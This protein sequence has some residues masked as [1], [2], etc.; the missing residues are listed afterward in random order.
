MSSSWDTDREGTLLGTEEFSKNLGN[1]KQG[2][3][4]SR[5]NE[6]LREKRSE[7]T[8]EELAGLDSPLATKEKRPQQSFS[9]K[10]GDD[11]E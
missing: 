6:R 8:P 10:L 4:R 5:E 2:L 1:I 7:F 3:S 9:D 11:L